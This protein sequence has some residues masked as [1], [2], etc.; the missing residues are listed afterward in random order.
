MFEKYISFLSPWHTTYLKHYLNGPDS[1]TSSHLVVVQAILQTLQL[2]LQ[3]VQMV[4]WMEELNPGLDE[5]YQSSRNTVWGFSTS[6]RKVARLI[7]ADQ[8][9][10]RYV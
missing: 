3:H 8:D 6:L 9:W 5:T 10:E 1:V 2:K 4:W 7:M